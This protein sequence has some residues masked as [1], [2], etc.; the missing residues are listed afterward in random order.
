MT[1]PKLLFKESYLLMIKNSKGT[2]MF[3]DFFGEI[4]GRKE[5]LTKDGQ[6]SCAF[7]VS[8]I[9]YHFYLIRDLHLTVNGTIRDMKKA[10]WFKT[11]KPKKGSVILWKKRRDRYHLGF[12]LGGK[13]SISN[14]KRKRTPIIHGLNNPHGEK[15][16]IESFFSHKKIA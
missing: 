13:K 11:R 10:G 5:N 4:N 12:Y 2:K 1:K 9:L 6:R 15:R 3:R 14:D 16:Q 8:S 7:F